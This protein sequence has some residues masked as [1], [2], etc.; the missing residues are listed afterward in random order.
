MKYRIE[1]LTKVLATQNADELTVMANLIPLVHYG[2]ADLLAETKNGRKLQGKWDHSFIAFDGPW[3]VGFIM[4]YERASEKSPQY[5][6]STLYLSELAVVA[7]RQRQG[8]GRGLLQH[9]LKANTGRGFLH[10]SGPF[11]FS[12]QTNANPSNLYILDMYQSVGFVPRALKPYDNRTDV[13]MGFMPGFPLLAALRDPSRR[14]GAIPLATLDS[15]TLRIAARAILHDNQGRVALLRVAKHNYHK[16]P[17]GGVEPGEGLD[18]ALIRELQEETGCAIKITGS[19][20][21]I[22][23]YRDQEKLHQQ[24][25]CYSATVAIP[26]GEPLFTPDEQAEGFELVWA[27]SLPVA[28][29]MLQADKPANYDGAFIQARD[30]TFLHAAIKKDRSLVS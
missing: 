7:S 24:S 21:Q 19:I 12:L 10:V 3:P 23:E 5:P 13:V 20:G 16:L 1:P 26:I 8:L 30:L 17:G 29:T 14:P 15:Y 27:A 11:N 4:G 2:P 28:L 18:Q 22:D 25:F 6:D 9:F